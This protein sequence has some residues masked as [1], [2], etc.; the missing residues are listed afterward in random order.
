MSIKP[1]SNDDVKKLPRFA[2]T[3]RALYDQLVDLMDVANQLGM[4][5]AADYLKRKFDD[6]K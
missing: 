5:D 3:Q 6:G 1:F 2:Q 4:Y